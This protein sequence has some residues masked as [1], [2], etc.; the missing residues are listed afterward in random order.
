MPLLLLLL[1]HCF[2]FVHNLLHFGLVVR[3]VAILFWR[4]IVFFHPFFDGCPSIVNIH[5]GAPDVN[6]RLE[7]SVVYI[8]YKAL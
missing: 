8:S 5:R 2:L 6:S 7:A 4:E 1:Y 3:L